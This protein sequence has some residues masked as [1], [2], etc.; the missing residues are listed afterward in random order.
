MSRTTH[1]PAI[2]VIFFLTMLNRSRIMV[3]MNR[4]PLDTQAQVVAALCEGNSMRGT[5]RLTGAAK[6][7]ILRL[8]ERVGFACAVHHDRVI[9]GIDAKLVQCDEIWTYVQAKQKNVPRPLQGTWGY[10][11]AYTWVALD[12][13]SKLVIS[14]L[15][16]QRTSECA[17]VFM[18]DLRDRVAG[19]IQI[20]TDGLSFYRD[21]VEIAFHGDADFGQLI[22]KYEA[23]VHPDEVRYSPPICKGAKRVRVSGRPQHDKI[24]TSYVERQ[25][26]TM[27]MKMRRFTRLT[28][29]FSK[30]AENL[31]WA[32][33]LHFIHYNFCRVH[34]TLKTTPAIAAG[35]ASHV[36]SVHDILT[37]VESVEESV[38]DVKTK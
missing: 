8:L 18:H 23:V 22:K 35:I 11:D 33:A 24:S 14:W 3:N 28:N 12:S 29:A 19:R 38:A 32:L 20:S 6:G 21:A 13:R 37:M 5:C 36:W 30:K 27:R 17:R 15:L 4:L 25:N 9:R 34:Q 2:L 31:E 10:G 7:T 1:I 26:L 16:G